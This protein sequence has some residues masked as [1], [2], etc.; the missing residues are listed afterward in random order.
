MLTFQ[1]I[2]LKLQTFWAAQGCLIWQPYNQ[3][4]GAGTMNPA[5]YLR[6]LGPEP[7]NV[8]YVEPSVRPDDGRFG[9]NPN[10]MYTHTQFQVILKPAPAEPQALYLESLKAIGIDPA[11]HDIRFV[12]DNWES[13]ALGAWGLG[14]EV[15]LDGLEITQYTYFQQAGGFTLHP[16]SLELTYGL[17]RIAMSHSIQNVRSVWDLKWDTHRTYGD[18]NLQAEIERCKYAF[19]DSDVEVLHELFDNYEGEAK[20]ALEH[21]LVVPAHDY[22]LNCSHTFNLLDTHGAVGV[23]ERARYFARMRDLAKQ[24]AVEYVKQ[25]EEM[26]HPWLK[27][28]GEKKS[29]GEAEHIL[30]GI[31]SPT[32]PLTSSPMLLRSPAPLLLEVGVEELPAADVT[33]AQE[34]LGKHLASALDEAR[35]DHG[36]ITLYA[37]PRRIAA[38][39]EKVAPQQR[40]LD[41]LVRGPSAKVAFDAEGKP[42]QAAIGFAKRFNIDPATLTVQ[43]DAQGRYVYAS[44]HENGKPAVE[45]LSQI[46]PGVIAKINFEKTMRWN[47]TNIAFSRP[48]RWIAALLG[49]QVIPFE[50]AGVRSS[51]V[52]IGPRGMGSKTFHIRA[53]NQYTKQIERQAVIGKIDARREVIRQQVQAAAATVNGRVPAD[54]GL[55]NEVTNLVEQPTALLGS[56]EADYLQIPKQVL[57]TVMRKHQRYFAVVDQGSGALLPHFIAVRNGNEQHLDEVRAGNEAVLRARFADAAYFFRHDIEKPLDAYLPKLE[58]LTFQAKLGSML[59]KAKRIETLTEEIGKAMSASDVDLRIA[60]RAAQLCKADLATSMVIDFTSLQGIMGRE[61]YKINHGSD[62]ATQVDAVASAI[63]E[64]YLPRYAGDE[65]P[66]TLAGL[67][68]SLADKLDSIAGLFAVGLAPKGS[69]DP[70]ALRRS[71]IGVVQNLIESKRSFSLR[72]GLHAAALRLPVRASDEALDAAHK[73]IVERQR[74]LLLESSNGQGR[75]FD[76]VDAVLAAQGD[77]PYRALVG[78]EQLSDWVKREE[79]TLMLAAYSRSA[80]I[81]RD[82]REALP[83]DVSADS[84]P[85]TQ[86]LAQAVTALQPA[87]NVNELMSNLKSLVAP[88][89]TFFEKVLVM[90]DDEAVRRVR[91]ALLQR[92]VMQAQGIA[93]LSKLEGF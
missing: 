90:A 53:A 68:V 24:V 76:V 25:R 40:P 65:T 64:H 60:R 92:V 70:F 56:F 49:R 48:I 57:M 45:V 9:E 38:V 89:S 77:D 72:A 30:K 7:W 29:A 79:W 73:F 61:Y 78:V 8:A 17:E 71:A 67:I 14:W 16:V 10:R 50:Y 91:L 85:A 23:T 12:E 22:V 82:L 41:E 93:D 43:E 26:G 36:N 5:T 32:L 87:S 75:R 62:D 81:T 33:L 88:I 84:D 6:V 3:V 1:D 74:A 80:R 55:L 21:G 54:E 28:A 52:S 51:N 59:D 27:D 63:F 42:T 4:V 34:L 83:L 18:V 20:R 39:V 2:I 11:H 69:A 86:A 13:P 19:N 37:T 47:D 66:K 58:T 15:W 35:L 31:S 44:K 46:L